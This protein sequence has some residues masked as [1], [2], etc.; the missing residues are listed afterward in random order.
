MC[1]SMY[2]AAPATYFLEEKKRF[3]KNR[4]RLKRK[5]LSPRLLYLNYPFENAGDK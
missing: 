5:A 2:P 4:E 1:C 3:K